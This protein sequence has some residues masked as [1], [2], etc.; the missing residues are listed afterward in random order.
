MKIPVRS[1]AVRVAC[2]GLFVWLLAPAVLCGADLKVGT[3]SAPFAVNG[4]G[5]KP[6]S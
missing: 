4:T 5:V 1:S 3:A 2:G 6:D